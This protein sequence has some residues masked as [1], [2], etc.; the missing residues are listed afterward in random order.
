MCPVGR[1][2]LI[3]LFSN[4]EEQKSQ[5]REYPLQSLASPPAV[6]T[7]TPELAWSKIKQIL[8]RRLLSLRAVWFRSRVKPSAGAPDLN[9]CKRI[10]V[11]RNDRLGDV[12]LTFP[13]VQSVKSV[14]PRAE[15]IYAVRESWK[16]LFRGQKNVDRVIGLPKSVQQ[17]AKMLAEVRPDLIL[18]PR[19]DPI[20]ETALLCEKSG[21]KWRIG[22]AGYGRERYF[23]SYRNPPR[24]QRHFVDE[25][26]DLLELWPDLKLEPV[27]T[28]FLEVPPTSRA[29]WEVRRSEHAALSAG[30]VCIHPGAF[31]ES[32]RWPMN[33]FLEL[34]ERIRE[35][36]KRPVIWFESEEVSLSVSTLEDDP[37]IICLSDLT[38][39]QLAAVLGESTVF[40]GNNSGPL[41][42]A[43]ALGTPTVSMMGPAVPYRWG[44]VGAEHWVARLGVACSPCNLGWCSHHTCLKAI[45]VDQVFELVCKQVQ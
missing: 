10:L 34:S 22:F 42:L 23:S 20:M 21:A 28:P 17:Q 19:T 7:R 36:L 32:Q 4:S 25:A 35:K 39:D 41:H 29:W 5:T 24:D 15:V 37:G 18:D 31:Y 45:S 13:F 6:P 2:R 30:Y 44:P 11:L 33:H 9:Q 1:D 14:V 3:D 12:V 40:V 8:K 16:S 26:V 43:C 38:I 27:R